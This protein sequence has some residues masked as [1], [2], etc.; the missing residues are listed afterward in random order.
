MKIKE[1]NDK[2]IVFDNGYILKYYHEQDCC[3]CVYADFKVL[4]DYNVSTKTGKTINIKDVDFNE[5]LIDLIEGI[6]DLGFNMVSKIR[7]KFFVPCYN[8][9]NGY[10]ND[11]LELYLKKEKGVE[12]LDITNYVKDDI[13]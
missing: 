4:K 11:E 1:I 10:Y 6:K 8:E 5:N 13:Y 2:N 12:K 7:E 3:E 9:Q